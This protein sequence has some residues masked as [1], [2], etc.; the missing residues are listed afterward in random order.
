M[1]KTEFELLSEIRNLLKAQYSIMILQ[2]AR[3]NGMADVVRQLMKNK[4]LEKEMGRALLNVLQP[5]EEE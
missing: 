1:D 5:G 3:F 4:L 2:Q